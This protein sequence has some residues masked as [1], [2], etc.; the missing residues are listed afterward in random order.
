M[1]NIDEMP[2]GPEMDRLIAAEVMGWKPFFGPG[3]LGDGWGFEFSSNG[4]PSRLMVVVGG[5]SREFSPSAN[6]A[7]AWEVMRKMV[8][9]TRWNVFAAAV[10]WDADPLTALIAHG[11]LAP[12]SICRCALKI[13][14]SGGL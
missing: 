14:R 13:A 1:S 2:A 7:H 12:L 4:K 9:C 3:N 11:D 8:T 10:A 5:K 6:S